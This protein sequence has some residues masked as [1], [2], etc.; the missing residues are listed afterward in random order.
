MT[1]VPKISGSL[2]AIARSGNDDIEK[3]TVKDFLRSPSDYFPMIRRGHAS[4]EEKKEVGMLSWGVDITSRKEREE[5]LR[6]VITFY[7]FC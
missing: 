6:S 5:S 2:A 1:S 4:E 7:V 3:K